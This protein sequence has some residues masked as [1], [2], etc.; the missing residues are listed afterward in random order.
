MTTKIYYKVHNP[1]NITEQSDWD[2]S[3]MGTFYAKDCDIY[4]SAMTY[5][6]NYTYPLNQ[7]GEV[8]TYMDPVA[9]PIG[10]PSVKASIGLLTGFTSSYACLKYL[11]P[12]DSSL[13]TKVGLKPNTSITILDQGFLPDNLPIAGGIP[14][15]L[16]GMHYLKFQL[17]TGQEFVYGHYEQLGNNVPNA[18]INIVQHVSEIIEYSTIQKCPF[19]F[20][21]N[22]VYNMTL[23]KIAMKN[24]YPN[25]PQYPQNVALTQVSYN[26]GIQITGSTSVLALTGGLDLDVEVIPPQTPINYAFDEQ[27]AI[28]FD[29]KTLPKS[30]GTSSSATAIQDFNFESNGVNLIIL[31]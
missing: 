23:L 28:I 30:K 27:S 10:S 12:D 4:T 25:L 2:R 8:W 11:N 29:I 24:A 26:S 21:V 9:A 18:L 14:D 5:D 7:L 31:V 20:I 3:H 16:L 13:I 6:P 19:I 1:A 15:S 17:N 22:S